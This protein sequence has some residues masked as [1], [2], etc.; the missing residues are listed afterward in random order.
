[1]I[2][3]HLI[4]KG[5]GWQIVLTVFLCSLA[6]ELI[7]RYISKDEDFYQNN[8]YPLTDAL[9]VSGLISY[10]IA[11]NSRK[12]APV[13]NV[14]VSTK[15]KSKNPDTLFF[16]PIKYWSLILFALAILNMAIRHR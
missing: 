16:I 11:R 3:V 8:P 12:P 2:F 1:M 7:T 13:N 6:A 5:K 10:Y 14:T 15:V 4:W 9:L